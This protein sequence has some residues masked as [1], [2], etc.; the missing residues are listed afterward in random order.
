M[1]HIPLSQISKETLQ[2]W[3]DKS[4]QIL[5]QL[6]AETDPKMR[7]VI[8]HR[9][10]KHW[11][12]PELLNFLRQLSDGKC[13]YTEA[14]FTAEYPHLEHFRPKSCARNENGEKYHDGYWWLAFDINN[15]RLSKPIPNARK[16][17]YF[18]LRENAM[19]VTTVGI[20]VSRE[21]PLLLDPANED[22]VAL[23]SFN[24]LGM[25][26]PCKEPPIDLDD[27]DRARIE[28]SIKKYGLDD[29]DL[30]DQRKAVWVAI[31]ALFDEYAAAALKAKRE[32]CVESAGKAKQ[33][34]AELNKFLAPKH[35]FTAT[36]RDCF[37]SH[38]IGRSLLPQLNLM[39]NA[40]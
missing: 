9:N 6:K 11:R 37:Y 15:Y 19:A 30:C 28:F 20:S 25:P 38:K 8:I 36:I 3:Q 21:S 26:E 14:R 22:D 18:P 4:E 32:R 33:I 10:R 24:A 5:E 39:S 17:T 35:E 40:A 12:D 7:K 31:H 23:I 2:T 16:G 29:K 1:R 27:W 13:W 34:K